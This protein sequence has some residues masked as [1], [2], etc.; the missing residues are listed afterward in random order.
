M[1]KIVETYKKMD[2]RTKSGIL[3]I[4]IGVVIATLIIIEAVTSPVPPTPIPNEITL[5]I[6]GEEGIDIVLQEDGVYIETT[7]INF[8]GIDFTIPV[9]WDV[10]ETEEGLM[11]SF[12]HHAQGHIL[13]IETISSSTEL[14][15][16]NNL[17]LISSIFNDTIEDFEFQAILVSMLPALR[18]QYTVEVGDVHYD[19]IGFLFPNRDELIYVQF[20][21]PTGEAKDNDLLRFVTNMIIQLVLPPSDFPPME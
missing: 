14:P 3:V 19:I 6:P 15:L 1:K 18:H 7:I 9:N 10:K 12:V 8:R 5:V 4:F 16:E 2:F 11:I 20:G 13:L 21:T 17:A